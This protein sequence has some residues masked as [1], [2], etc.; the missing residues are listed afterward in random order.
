MNLSDP[1]ADMLTRVRNATM[2]RHHAVD[3]PYSRIKENIAGILRNEGFIRGYEITGH[4][5]KTMLRVDLKYVDNKEP[6]LTHLRRI[7]K[8]GLRIYSSHRD[9]PRVLGGMGILILST[10][11]GIITNRQARREK[12][13]GEV[14]C[15]IW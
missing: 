12:V 4:G 5:K 1:I 7:S 13:G 6:V 9:L 10:P 2:A 8:P 3:V 14:L 11:R 15:E